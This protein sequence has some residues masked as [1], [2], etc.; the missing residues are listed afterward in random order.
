MTEH[1]ENGHT[2]L[3]MINM[4]IKECD[5]R[6]T[7]ISNRFDD[8]EGKLDTETERARKFRLW[9]LLAIL[10]TGGGGI[11]LEDKVFNLFR[12]LF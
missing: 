11:L 10:G 8:V 1:N 12:M 2:A 6:H 7:L 4:H 3:T 9:F 5:K